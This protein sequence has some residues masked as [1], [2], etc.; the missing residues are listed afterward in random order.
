MGLILLSSLSSTTER[1]FFNAQSSLWLSLS[2]LL[3][4]VLLTL[5]HKCLLFGAQNSEVESLPATFVL[6]ESGPSEVG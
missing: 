3:G 6:V 1:Q 4:Y 5:I 2:R